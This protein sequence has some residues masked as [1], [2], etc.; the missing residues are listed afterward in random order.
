MKLNYV[1]QP[2]LK[3]DL[4]RRTEEMKE[5]V[6]AD[7]SGPQVVP[8]HLNLVVCLVALIISVF[9][10]SFAMCCYSF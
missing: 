10:T 5:D 7:G 2:I 6:E 9:T 8:V 4:I 1:W 3:Q